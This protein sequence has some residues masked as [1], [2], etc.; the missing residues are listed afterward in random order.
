MPI[1]QSH[2]VGFQRNAAA[3]QTLGDAFTF[4]AAAGDQYLGDLDTVGLP[5]IRAIVS[6][7]S[8]SAGTVDVGLQLSWYADDGVS[9][10]ED[11]WITVATANI[12]SGAVGSLSSDF[13]ATR[14]RLVLSRSNAAATG[15]VKAG[16]SAYA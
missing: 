5:H 4:T 2:G 9:A 3:S 14:A 8:I 7:T 12:A 15:A 11:E 6:V 1:G 16:L 13:A 10:P